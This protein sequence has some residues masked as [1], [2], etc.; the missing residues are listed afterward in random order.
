MSHILNSSTK[1]TFKSRN[2]RSNPWRLST[3]ASSM[4]HPP[5]PAPAP[6]QFAS[7]TCSCHFGAASCFDFRQVLLPRQADCLLLLPPQLAAQP[8]SVGPRHVN[9]QSSL[10]RCA[11]PSP[12]QLVGPLPASLSSCPP[13]GT[14]NPPP[15]RR[16]GAAILCRA[17]SSAGLDGASHP[18]GGGWRA[19]WIFFSTS[20]R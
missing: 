16:A 18:A 9:K 3:Q 12:L 15:S 10:R 11:A 14:P 13:D 19:L 4:R 5:G 6:L 17:S 20:T 1:R 7:I 8:W 2:A